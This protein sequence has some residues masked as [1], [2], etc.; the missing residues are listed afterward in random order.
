MARARLAA[1]A[2]ALLLLLHPAMSVAA[3]DRGSTDAMTAQAVGWPP[4]TGLLV[5][6]VVTGGASA[7]DEYLELT[8]ASAVPLD[9]AGLE[10]VYVTASGATV[11]RKAAWDGSLIVEPGR[12]VLLANSLGTYATA[13][14]ATYAGGLAATGGT[15]VLRSVG[16]APIDSVSWGT[17]ASDLV[18]GSPAP[19]PPAG[20]SIERRPGGMAGNTVDSN[21]NAADLVVNDSPEARNLAAD[22]LPATPTA[23]PTPTPCGDP[24]SAPDSG[25][26]AVGL[27]NHNP[28]PDPAHEPVAHGHRLA[29]GGSDPDARG[30]ARPDARRHARPDAV[31]TPAPT[32][33]PSAPPVATP[34]PAPT[35]PT[36]LPT[37]IADARLLPDGTSTS[38]EG[39]LTTALGALEGGRSAFIQDATGGIALYLDAAVS[40]QLPAGTV[41][42]ASGTVASRYGQRTLRIDEADLDALGWSDLPQAVAASTGTAGEALEGRRLEVSGVVIDSPTTLSDGLG[43]NVDDGTGP[44]RVVVGPDALG[45]L[46]V[47]QGLTVRAQGPLGQRDSSG[48][49]ASGYRL[50]ATLAGELALVAPQPSP[51]PTPTAEPTP[52]PSPSPVPTATPVPSPTATATA[53]P[54][55]TPAPSPVPMTIATARVAPVGSRVTVRGVVIAEAGRLGTPPLFAIADASAGIVV[56]LPDGVVAPE[57]GTLLEVR[58]RI[59]D[60]YGQTELRPEGDGIA[61]LGASELPEPI[62]VA[63]G[64]AGEATEGKLAVISGSILT[65]ATRA[66][67]GDLSFTIGDGGGASLAVRADASA[68]IDKASLRKGLRGSFVGVLGQRASRK[69]RL[70]GYRLWL[71]D[72]RDVQL[73]ASPSPSATSAGQTSGAST[74]PTRSTISV[75]RVRQGRTV[76]VEGVLTVD[77]T[78]L[79]ATGRRTIVE[80]ASGAIEVYLPSA[81]AKLR[82]GQLVRVTGTVGRA[83][84]APRLKADEVTVIGARE[85]VAHLLRGR[86]SAATEWS[87]VKA[88]GTLVNVRRSGDRWT[89]ELDTASGRVLLQGLAGSGIA[90]TTLIEGRATTIV[91]IV[92]RPYPTATDRRFSI[93][94]RSPRDVAIGPGGATTAT[95][96]P[97]SRSSGG[98]PPD[99]GD[100]GAVTGAIDIDLRDLAAN[101]GRVVRVGGL[102]TTVEGS[103]FMLDDGTAV[104]GVVLEGVAG[105]VAGRLRPGDALNATGTPESRDEPVLLVTDPGAIELAADL[106][107]VVPADPTDD[108]GAAL[109]GDPRPGPTDGAS[110]LASATANGSTP[111][112]P[113]IPLTIGL[114]LVMTAITTTTTMLRRRHARRRLETR[115]SA[116]LTAIRGEGP[117][118]IDGARLQTSGHA[119]APS[120][121]PGPA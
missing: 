69:G 88:S 2:A 80:D 115:I 16:G 28:D 11:T 64:A 87:L 78:L 98:S 38:V 29:V 113:A 73:V 22:P 94:P 36:P 117:G 58:G 43:L 50:Y 12:H 110:D 111:A 17:A 30:H 51:T 31:V 37:S 114:L 53:A 47:A 91:G 52:T 68:G 55:A 56:R 1:L 86:P 119:I 120:G 102:V 82:A 59:A 121:P 8:N 46:S 44:I 41:I 4:S 71:R 100:P 18:E 85:P 106:T 9:L 20:S 54:T 26:N 72:P 34:T 112:A 105:S 10:V 75:A 35:P 15:I 90:A 33:P 60:P 45:V 103:G 76:T 108:R 97:V 93:V 57:R 99:A 23:S 104:R 101:I 21:D 79:D 39:V 70:D 42:R 74:P 7:S 67:S 81:D 118:P 66:T 27:P 95:G 24:D 5:A 107:A 14:D 84:N 96:A 116:R 19:A 32:A 40:D 49:G 25:P 109:A 48:T 89:A 92:K 61:S 77:R 3:P 13:A 83:W 63:V 6:E 62:V 65:S